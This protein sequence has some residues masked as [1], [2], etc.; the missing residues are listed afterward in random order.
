M[1]GG[2][3]EEGEAGEVGVGEGDGAERLLEGVEA[4]VVQADDRPGG[5]MTPTKEGDVFEE[6]VDVGV[7]QAQ[8][9]EDALGLGLGVG[10]EQG[11]AGG[12]GS[13]ART[14]AP[15]RRGAGQRA[16]SCCTSQPLPA[17]QV[18]TWLPSSRAGSGRRAQW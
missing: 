1:L 15:V 2:L 6:G 4:P 7:G 17:G 11:A 13:T 5:A 12:P 8:V 10:G 18:R 9:G 16:R 14:T 3:L